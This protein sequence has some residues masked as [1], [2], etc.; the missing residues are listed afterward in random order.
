MK[1]FIVLLLIISILSPLLAGCDL[2]DIFSKKATDIATDSSTTPDMTIPGISEIVWEEKIYWEGDLN[3]NFVVGELM[4][5][6]DKAISAPN[7]VHTPDFFVGVEVIKV[8]D[9][10]NPIKDPQNIPD[11]YRQI[12]HL[13]LSDIY[14]TKEKTFEA[15]EIIAQ[16]EGVVSASPNLILSWDTIPNDPFFDNSTGVFDQW[17]HENIEVEK[18]WD[19]TTGTKAVKVGVLDKGVS[20]HLDLDANYDISNACDF[21]NANMSDPFYAKIDDD[22]HGTHIAGIIGATG[23]N[24]I[25]V[26]GVNWNVSIVQ[27]RVMGAENI[28]SFQNAINWAISDSVDIISMASSDYYPMPT[29]EASIRNYCNQG[30]LFICSTGNKEQDNDVYGQYN[31]PSYYASDSYDNKI[32]NMITVGRVDNNDCRPFGAN[33]GFETIDIY[34]PGQ[35]ILSTF[36]ADIC[37]EGNY[38]QDTQ[39]GTYWA[40]ECEYQ[41]YSDGDGPS[42]DGEQW[43]P[44]SQHQTDGYHYMSGSSMSTPYVSGVAALLLSIN[45]DLNASQIEECILEGADTIRITVGTN[46]NEYQSVKKLNAW[47][48]FKYLMYHYPKISHTL[49]YDDVQFTDEIDTYGRYYNEHTSMAKLNIL[50]NRNYTFTVSSNDA[51]NVTVYD[52]SFEEVEIPQTI[53]NNGSR[54]EFSYT[55][56]KGTYYMETN[57]VNED[58]EGTI[59][60]NIDTLPHTHEYTEW[61][62]HSPTHHIESC[63]CGLKGT[64]TSMHV[65]KAG[66]IVNLRAPCMYC[67]AIILI[68]NDFVQ[69]G[70]AN[71]A[72]VTLNGSYILPNGIIVLV[73][74]DI[75]AYENGTLVWYDKDDLPQTQ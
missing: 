27:I 3:A 33:W 75:E 38:G 63:E 31:Y 70:P 22:G 40:C 30:G 25:G 13:T 73:D 61:S 1:R 72:K 59:T 20:S 46:N 4:V 39:W 7:K 45:P 49:R 24:G 34:A 62:Y 15:M 71:L 74:E 58:V 17:G 54:I 28:L 9:C 51:I 6:L 5:I 11:D 65:I 53:T 47:G 64:L 37:L 52:S 67:G 42:I 29:I 35:H 16:L 69:V 14:D 66:T 48:S 12:L 19:F 44:I 10:S 55:F 56:P 41:F 8:L 2:S 32:V 68:G 21:Y 57:Y 50:V 26:S 36:P 23:N 60:V 18:V 43:I